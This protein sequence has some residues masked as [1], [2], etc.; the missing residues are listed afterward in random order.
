MKEFGYEP[1]GVRL[2][3]GDLAYL[4]VQTREILRKYGLANV[5][6]VASNDINESV[7][8][9]LAKQ[10]HEIDTFGIGT[11]LVT[12]QAQ[13]ALGMVFKLVE[14]DNT[15]CIKLSNEFEKTTL[16]GAKDAYRLIGTNGLALLDIMLRK[17]DE[18]PQVNVPILAQHPFDERLRCYVR[19]SRVV[20]LLDCVFDG[21]LLIS[22]PSINQIR[23]HALQ[24][25]KL[26]RQDYIR[27]LNPTRYK[28]SVSDDLAKFT[29]QLWQREAPIPVLD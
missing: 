4:S 18:S 7:L 29:K 25:M 15:P 9:S 10:G 23:E 3:S 24:E 11:N 19:P 14:I 20:K 16:P 21:K 26:L 12:C 2:D 17:D 8:H 1:V 27:E 28:V 13:P 22:L 5:S 6:I